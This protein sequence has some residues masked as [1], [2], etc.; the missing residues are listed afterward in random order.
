MPPDQEQVVNRIPL[1]AHDDAGLH[2][3]L[4]GLEWKG[5]VRDLQEAIMGLNECEGATR[6]FKKQTLT[7][8]RF[9]CT[10]GIIAA[11]EQREPSKDVGHGGILDWACLSGRG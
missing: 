6:R 9:A 4:E 3:P 2:A 10:T 8:Q 7:F 1:E 11:R 5:K